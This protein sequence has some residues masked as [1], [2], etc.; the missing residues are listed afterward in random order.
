MQVHLGGHLAWYDAYKRSRLE[1][2]LDQPITLIELLQNLGVPPA[3]IAV[4]AVNGIAVE[5]EHARVS[6]QDHVDVYP[7]VGGG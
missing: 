6:N 4:A 2:T 3:E 5:L 1:I 7:P